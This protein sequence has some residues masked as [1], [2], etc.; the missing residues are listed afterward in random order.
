MVEIPVNEF[1]CVYESQ[2]V[3]YFFGSNAVNT[4]RFRP[5]SEVPI[6]PHYVQLLRTLLETQ[7]V[8]ATLCEQIDLICHAMFMAAFKDTIDGNSVPKIDGRLI[9]IENELR[10]RYSEAIDYEELAGRHCLSFSSLRRLWHKHH[11]KSPHEFIMELRN[12]EAREL[13]KDRML[14]IS[15]VARAVGYDDPQYFARF[16]ARFNHCSPSQYRKNMG[17]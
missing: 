11:D 3:H 7:P 15:D 6:V 10:R 4:P 14:S 1:Y 8:S 2:Y 17:N 5:L 13:L 16:F 9:S 12:N